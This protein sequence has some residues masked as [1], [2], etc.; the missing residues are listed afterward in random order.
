MPLFIED[1]TPKTVPFLIKQPEHRPELAGEVDSVLPDSPAFHSGVKPGDQIFSV[2]GYPVEDVIDV[3][4]Y[5]AEEICR[6]GVIRHGQRFFLDVEKHIDETLGIV[7]KDDLF[8]GVRLCANRCDFCFVDQ[9]PD[10]MRS[11]LK[12][13]DDDYRLSFL[14]GNF[15]TL[16]NLTDHDWNRI[17]TQRL[18]PL[19]VTVHATDDQARRRLLRNKRANPIMEDIHRLISGGIELHTQIV[20]CEGFND[21][22]VLDRTIT[23][24]AALYP[25]VQ[26]L[27]V[28]PM[29]VTDYRLE[30]NESHP[31]DGSGAG[32]ILR[33][34]REHQRGFERNL[35]V[36]FV[37]PSD[38]FYILAGKPF[39]KAHT[40]QGFPQLSNGLGGCRLFL[41][42]IR[43]L[44]RTE[45]RQSRNG[46]VQ[47]V[48]GVLAA[49][50][51]QSFAQCIES[52][53]GYE[54]QVVPAVNKWYGETVT[55][56]GLLTGRD[57]LSALNKAGYADLVLIPEVML[58]DDS[59]IFLDNMSIPE[60]S[61]SA[62]KEILVTSNWPAQ[63]FES[64]RKFG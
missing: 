44:N 55:V 8:D 28:V 56:A 47:L 19:Y 22:K 18:S 63:A 21:G 53:L 4:F 13:R 46:R 25:S 23:D 24:L 57:V 50:V 16:T 51:M 27:A 64:L 14:H 20:L 3:Q 61:K 1:S 35:G 62:G 33:Q 9:Q 60:L 58:K 12:L 43:Y 38:E 59:D 49:G 39:P 11:T 15:V 26:T 52:L 32:R 2:N 48:T 10:G 45:A 34:I 6:L 17:F 40:Y 42:E 37:Y 29:G 31:Y 5:A 54:A 30:R 36:R 41:D 7:F